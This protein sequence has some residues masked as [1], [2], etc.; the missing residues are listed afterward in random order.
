M[1][2]LDLFLDGAPQIKLVKTVFTHEHLP[3]PRIAELGVDGGFRW[4]KGVQALTE[5]LLRYAAWGHGTEP[6]PDAESPALQGCRPSAAASL[7]DAL[8]QIPAWLEEMFGP[9]HPGTFLH[10]VVEWKNRDFKTTKGAPVVIAINRRKLAP[11]SIR[12][13]QGKERVDDPARL[14]ALADTI[15]SQRDTWHSD[16]APGANPTT[17]MGV[18]FT[19]QFQLGDENCMIELRIDGDFDSFTVDKRTQVLEAVRKAL[20]LPTEIALRGQR[21]GSVILK[22]ELPVDAADRLLGLVKEGAL[23]DYRVTD[24]WPDDPTGGS[25]AIR[26]PRRPSPPAPPGILAGV[27]NQDPLA[28]EELAYL[29]RAA[30]SHW[31]GTVAK[32]DFDFEREI[33]DEVFQSVCLMY[34][35]NLRPS[36]AMTGAGFPAT[37]VIPKWNANLECMDFLEIA[38]SSITKA[39]AERTETRCTHD[40]DGGDRLWPAPV[41]PLPAR[42]GANARQEADSQSLAD[43]GA[44]VANPSPMIAVFHRDPFEELN[45]LVKQAM[46]LLRPDLNRETFRLL[47]ELIE[48]GRHPHDIA[49]QFRISVDSVLASVHHALELMHEEYGQLINVWAWWDRMRERWADKVIWLSH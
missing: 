7:N 38:Y 40:S 20:G 8:S 26:P 6:D 46:R 36:Q 45:A 43:L 21:R 10:H 49:L 31:F 41:D 2:G 18:S 32:R 22:L 23:A 4:T 29:V 13:F 39:L 16:T 14:K 28:L 12:V 9:D 42:R 1:V 17:A 33:F 47:T 44:G 27:A 48:L 35:T 24:A 34:M 11:D 37:R 5:L 19:R 15:H 25:A 30:V 3:K